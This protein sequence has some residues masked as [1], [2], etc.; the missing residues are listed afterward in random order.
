[1]SID[2]EIKVL[3]EA[4]RLIK[5]G[6]CKR[7]EWTTWNSFSGRNEEHQE[8]TCQWTRRALR[9][10]MDKLGVARDVN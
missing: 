7:D 8:T 9:M 4:V 5:S 2:V 10:A 1:M 6:E 3:E